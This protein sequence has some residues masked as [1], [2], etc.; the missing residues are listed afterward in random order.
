MLLLSHVTSLFPQSIIVFL[1]TSQSINKERVAGLSDEV[2]GVVP[3]HQNSFSPSC[4]CG[5]DNA[6]K[7]SR[8]LARVSRANSAPF[9]GFL[10]SEN[11]HF[12]RHVN[13]ILF[14]LT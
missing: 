6:T 4:L 12:F 11:K 8:E 1:A 5:D 2:T 14:M 10:N 9:L 7:N 3:S 13:V